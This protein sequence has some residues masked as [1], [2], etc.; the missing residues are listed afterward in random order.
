MRGGGGGRPDFKK[1]IDE[2]K[3]PSVGFIPLLKECEAV[4]SGGVA[5]FQN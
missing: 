5:G 1:A 3:L 2:V 4:S